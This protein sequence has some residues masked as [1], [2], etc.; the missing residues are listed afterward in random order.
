MILLAIVKFIH[1]TSLLLVFGVSLL[2]PLLLAHPG[3][4]ARLRNLFDPLL[5][6][7]AGL[8]LIS[9]VGWLLLTTADMVGSLDTAALSRVLTQTFFGKVWS[10]HLML[11]LGLLICLRIPGARTRV[12]ARPLSA[13]AVATLA[14]IGHGSLFDGLLGQVM[15]INQL[16]HLLC[17]GAWLGGLLALL[18]VMARPNGED[19]RQLLRRF[20]NLGLWLVAGIAITGLI[21]VRALT[22]TL[23]PWPGTSGFATVL[24]IKALLVL[25]M[26]GLA[27]FN[28][29]SLRDPGFDLQRLKISIGLEWL[30]G[31]A[32]LLAVS[33]LAGMAP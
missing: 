33:V 7:I 18:F 32:A 28:R 19:L 10:L 29:R 4:Q 21:N 22:G 25:A 5:C 24:N 11:C 3:Q 27:L 30:L 16:V 13:L 17:V 26:L 8:A 23:W 2:R 31:L 6:L 12:V 9:A 20:G 1:F 15:V 14:P